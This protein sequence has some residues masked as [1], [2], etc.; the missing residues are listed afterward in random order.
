[1]TRYF[2]TEHLLPPLQDGATAPLRELQLVALQAT[3]TLPNLL[4]KLGA[5]ST[6]LENERLKSLLLRLEDQATIGWQT[7]DL[8][9]GLGHL[10]LVLLPVGLEAL[11]SERGAAY[12]LL[13]NNDKVYQFVWR[14]AEH[15]RFT[16][17]HISQPSDVKFTAL[18]RITASEFGYRPSESARAGDISPFGSYPALPRGS[19]RSRWKDQAL[20][21]TLSGAAYAGLLRAEAERGA[22]MIGFSDLGLGL[23]A[24]VWAVNLE[25]LDQD[26]A[27]RVAPWW[28]VAPLM[29]VAWLTEQ[30][31][32]DGSLLETVTRTVL[33]LVPLAVLLLNVVFHLRLARQARGPVSSRPW[34]ALPTRAEVLAFRQGLTQPLTRGRPLPPPVVPGDPPG[35]Q[36]ED[37]DTGSTGPETP[38]TEVAEAELTLPPPSEADLRVLSACQGVLDEAL[39]RTLRHLVYQNGHTTRAERLLDLNTPLAEAEQEDGSSADDPGTPAL[40]SVSEA[41]TIRQEALAAVT[42]RLKIPY[43]N[44]NLDDLLRPRLDVLEQRL[45]QQAKLENSVIYAEVADQLAQTNTF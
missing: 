32:P 24:T 30:L 10:P 45:S 7:G 38:R 3:L 19:G 34:D 41:R 13:V 27:W 16:L 5:W 44:V 22:V 4:R 37:E 18:A 28:G 21:L 31:T 33:H 2:L 12:V 43:P 23:L 14:D 36:T 42:I 25:D 11:R 17:V 8:L 29:M 26:N 9:P 40:M 15:T 39:I 20:A 1:M 6:S 35:T